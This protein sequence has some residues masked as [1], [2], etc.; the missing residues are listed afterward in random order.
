MK[1]PIPFFELY[2]SFL[3]ITLAVV[4]LKDDSILYSGTS[5]YEEM[6]VFASAGVWAIAFSVSALVKIV[7]LA[8]R[9][10]WM[11]KLGLVFSLIIHGTIS[12]CYVVNDGYLGAAAFG[13]TA[14]FSFI[15]TFDVDKTELK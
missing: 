3:S 12:Y 1:K 9:V 8:C 11:R 13:M 6:L 5:V 4:M 2:V 14:V 7:G 15:T 10:L